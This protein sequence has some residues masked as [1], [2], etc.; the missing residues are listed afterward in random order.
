[1]AGAKGR[2]E[3]V[4][5]NLENF[6]ANVYLGVLR[7]Q[8][9]DRGFAV[10]GSTGVKAKA[11]RAWAEKNSVPYFASVGELNEAVDYYM[12][13]APSNPEEHL[14]LCKEVLPFG[15][16]TYVDKTFAPN[17]ATA[18]RIFSL[19]DKH[20]VPVQTTSALRYTGIQEFVRSIAP[21]EV[22]HMVTWGGGGSFGEYAIHPVELA[23]SCMGPGVKRLM[24][25]GTNRHV[26][27]LLDFSRN[28]TAVINVYTNTQTPYAASVTTTAE[29]RHFVVDTGEIFA[30]TA[31]AALDLFAS[32]QPTIDRRES[33]AIRRI[34]D[35]ASQKRP[36]KGFAAL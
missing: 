2:I 21:D 34:L 22:R 4:D 13:L 7:Q 23:I 10:T 31:A 25:R 28:R 11:S 17:L 20:G 1:M 35:V 5:Y 30:N 15:K 9:S 18:R 26:Q 32:G 36:L 14:A 6:H 33:L 27:L 16:A 19:A 24:R 8:L 29:T 3:F 12:V